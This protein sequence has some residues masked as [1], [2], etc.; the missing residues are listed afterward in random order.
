MNLDEYMAHDATALADLV[1]QGQVTA[2]ELL[3]LARQRMR[4]VNPAIN[5]VVIETALA[6][7]T[8]ISGAGEGPSGPFAGVPFLLKDLGQ[9]YK[10]Y[11]T[12]SGSKAL[13]HVIETENALV[14][15]RF[16]AAGLVIMGKTNTPELGAKGITEPALW[17]PARNPWDT[18]RTTGGSSGGSAAAVAAGVVPAAGANDGGGSIRIPSG[19]N[20]LVGLKASRGLTPYGPQT[21]EPMFGL[22]TQGV[23]TRT[24]RDSA[25]LLDAIVGPNQRADYHVAQPSRPFAEVITEEPGRLRIA[26]SARSAISGEASAQAQAA[27]DATAELLTDLGHEVVEIDPPYDD[28]ALAQTF[29]TIWFAQLAGN[30]AEIKERTGAG[31]FDFEADTLAMVEVGRANGVVALID[32]LGAITEYT[33]AMERFY[34]EYDYFLTP[35]IAQKP[36]EIGALDTPLALQAGARVAHRLHGGKALLK[37][38][39]IDQMIEE[40]LGWVPY[41]QMANLTG[42]PAI[43]VPVYWT[44]DDLPLGVQFNGRLGADGSLLQLAA[45]LEKARPWIDRFPARPTASKSRGH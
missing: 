26:Y 8:Q 22:V 23:V 24:V 1:K 17:G 31:D 7:D 13:R 28:K 15:D 12:S 3:E 32:A 21:G 34:T 40:N 5:A 9:E 6:A 44:D 41:T 20:G 42:R 25:G 4:E 14:T 11:P 37:T 10:G 43:N 19:C 38:G 45:Q 33:H 35:T 18:T 36:I 29:L 2:A 27:V 16:L 30:V 39:I